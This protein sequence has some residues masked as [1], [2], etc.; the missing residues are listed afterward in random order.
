MREFIRGYFD[1][2]GSVGNYQ[3]FLVGSEGHA[4]ILEYVREL[5]LR[6]GM[7]TGP[8]EIYREV[9]EERLIAGKRTVVRERGLRFSVNARDFLTVIG[10]FGHDARDRKLKEMVKG[11]K[12]TP[13][14]SREREQVL[15][16]VRKGLTIKEAARQVGVPYLTA[17]F[18][19]RKGTRS[20]DEYALTR[21]AR[22]V[23]RARG[24]SN[25]GPTG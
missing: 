17:Y 21:Q 19:V 18:W 1:S 8:I 16:L 10:G 23:W 4:H 11:R 22:R 25:P 2:D 12:W 13:W 20:W 5:C 15:E 24:D 9:G 14:S 3:V 6:L 7:R